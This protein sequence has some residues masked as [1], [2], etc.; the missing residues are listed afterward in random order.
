MP[1]YAPLAA[2]GRTYKLT[3]LRNEPD[4]RMPADFDYT[5]GGPKCKDKVNKLA[6]GQCLVQFTFDQ[7]APALRFCTDKRQPGPLVHVDSPAEAAEAARIACA[8]FEKTGSYDNCLP[9]GLKLGGVSGTRRRTSKPKPTGKYCV[10]RG[11]RKISCHDTQSAATT[12]A[13]DAR[14]RC[15]KARGAARC[16]GKTTVKKSR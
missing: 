6:K 4:Y 14:A 13:K 1:K 9:K 7:G 15:K 11:G 10:M 5:P 3:Q 16:K 12:A 8:C 2:K